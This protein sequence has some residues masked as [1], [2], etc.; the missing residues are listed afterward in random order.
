MDLIAASVF[1]GNVLTLSVVWGFTQFGKHDEDAPWLAYAAF[2]LP[3]S[4]FM[5]TMAANGIVPP[6]FDA[7]APQ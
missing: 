6:Q 1:L 3:I 4:Y 5:L 7:I 2:L